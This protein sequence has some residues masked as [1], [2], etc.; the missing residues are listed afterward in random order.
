MSTIPSNLSALYNNASSSTLKVDTS[1][2]DYKQEF[3]HL[4]LTSMKNQDPTNPMDSKDMLAQQAQFESLEQMQNLN[5]NFVTMMAMQNTNQAASMLGK[6]VTGTPTG[7][8]SAVTGVV[9]A[10]KFI[11]GTPVL[12]MTLPAG[13]TVDMNLSGVSEITL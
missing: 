7:A 5:T 8:T 3:L 4:L 1:S 12:E 13:G 11:N 6:T 9:S 10:V 2:K